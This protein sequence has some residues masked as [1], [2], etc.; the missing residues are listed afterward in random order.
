[1][2]QSKGGF[3]MKS[4]ASFVVLVTLASSAYAEEQAE[5][6]PAPGKRWELSLNLHNWSA[7]G[8]IKPAVGGSFDTVGIG[9]SGAVHW[10]V[11]QLGSGEML[12]GFDGGFMTSSSNSPGLQNDLVTTQIFISP[13]FKWMFGDNHRISLDGGIGWHWLDISEID[14]SYTYLYGGTGFQAQ[15][16]EEST[17]APYVGATWDVRAGTTQNAGAFSLGLKVHFL[18]FGLVRDEDPALPVTLGSMAGDLAGPMVVLQF[19]AAFR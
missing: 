13:S 16:W 1:M 11:M 19:G 8:D 3:D 10:P 18:D 2:N 14:A 12:L 6:G 15:Y 5:E 9:L 7:L 4:I 17:F